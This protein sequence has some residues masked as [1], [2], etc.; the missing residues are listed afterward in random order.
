MEI[1]VKSVSFQF[2]YDLDFRIEVLV[3]NVLICV[4]VLSNLHWRAESEAV[5]I[6]SH[7]ALESYKR[8]LAVRGNPILTYLQKCGGGLEAFAH[9]HYKKE[10]PQYLILS[11]SGYHIEI[12]FLLTLACIGFLDFKFRLT[13][14]AFAFLGC[15]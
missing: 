7:S 8:S 5:K 14:G 9:F 1:A 13:V 11:A 3:C 15:L 12:G 10:N 6:Q 4:A 2:R